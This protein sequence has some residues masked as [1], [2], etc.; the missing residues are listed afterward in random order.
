MLEFIMHYSE[1]IIFVLLLMMMWVCCFIIW[2]T[3]DDKE[4]F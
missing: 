3:P 2:I 1:L 4:L